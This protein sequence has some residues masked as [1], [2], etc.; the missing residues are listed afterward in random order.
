M[1]RAVAL[2]LHIARREGKRAQGS[3]GRCRSQAL[4]VVFPALTQEPGTAGCGV[5]PSG[6]GKLPRVPGG[7][8]AAKPVSSGR[9][10]FEYSCGSWLRK[11]PHQTRIA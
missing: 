2:D 6:R 4:P 11:W 3:L 9:D 10:R 5:G 1:T 7:G 8:P